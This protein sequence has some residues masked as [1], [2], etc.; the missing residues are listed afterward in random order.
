MDAH[1][2]WFDYF[3]TDPNCSPY[4]AVLTA[5][6]DRKARMSSWSRFWHVPPGV[7][8]SWQR[9]TRFHSLPNDS[10]MLGWCWIAD[11]S[12]WQ[13]TGKRWQDPADET[14]DF[15][16]PGLELKNAGQGQPSFNWCSIGMS[17]PRVLQIAIRWCQAMRQ[18]R[19]PVAVLLLRFWEL[20]CH[21]PCVVLVGS[22]LIKSH[23]T[24]AARRSWASQQGDCWP[25]GEAGSDAGRLGGC[26]KI[27]P[28]AVIWHFCLNTKRHR[29]PEMISNLYYTIL[30]GG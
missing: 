24:L 4:A 11:D 7:E 16:H 15:H 23:E 27:F 26:N 22:H 3:S 28:N 19:R 29:L 6:E 21:Y 13:Q 17:K 10:F 30:Y 18:K 25:A 2:C 12:R 20:N 5:L 14:W 1:S 9:L 8:T